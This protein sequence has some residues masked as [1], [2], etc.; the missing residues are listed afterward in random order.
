ME[1]ELRET[2]LLQIQDER[3]Y[4]MVLIKDMQSILRAYIETG[5]AR[6]PHTAL[7]LAKQSLEILKG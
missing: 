3:D 1:K 2:T 5:D 7:R 4:L 6:L